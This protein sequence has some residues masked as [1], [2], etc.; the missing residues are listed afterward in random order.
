M[1]PGYINNLL[2][3]DEI[4][5]S[6][7]PCTAQSKPLRALALL[8]D[9]AEILTQKLE[10]ARYNGAHESNPCHRSFSRHARLQ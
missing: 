2:L 9:V 5:L 6:R 1:S 4:S 7:G 8:G 10:F 3:S